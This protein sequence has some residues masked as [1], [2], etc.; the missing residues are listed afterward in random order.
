MLDEVSPVASLI[1]ADKAA[2]AAL[3]RLP[4]DVDNK[5]LNAA[6][7]V[8]DSV[9]NKL[10]KVECGKDEKPELA[11]V[12]KIERIVHDAIEDRAF[13]EPAYGKLLA[14]AVQSRLAELR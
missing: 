10:A 12:L 7:S 1:A 8:V 6:I 14:V 2:K 4:Y 13:I 3:N 9:K 5:T 11:F